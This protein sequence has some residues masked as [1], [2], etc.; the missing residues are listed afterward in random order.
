MPRAGSGATALA[1][2]RR[3]TGER[4]ILVARDRAQLEAVRDAAVQLGAQALAI[5]ADLSSVRGTRVLGA[6]LAAIAAPGATLVHNAGIWPSRRTMGQDG[7]ETAFVANGPAPLALQRV[8]LGAGTL[9]R[10]FR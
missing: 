2:A 8:R 4:L 1:L 3:R 7:L 6:Q 10:I 9:R 5:P